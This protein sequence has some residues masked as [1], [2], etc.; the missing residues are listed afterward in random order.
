MIYIHQA[1]ACS[2]HQLLT[3]PL[4]RHF[5]T[6]VLFSKIFTDDVPITSSNPEDIFRD[7]IL[8]K[9]SNPLRVN[10]NNNNIRN[11]SPSHAA[12]FGFF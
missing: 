4:L 5:G 7:D 6:D 11:L 10:N 3:T 8:I 9:S 1:V 12:N 2:E